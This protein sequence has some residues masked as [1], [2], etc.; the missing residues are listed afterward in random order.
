MFEE[1][2]SVQMAQT[3]ASMVQWVMSASDDRPRSQS[4][5][6]VEDIDLSLDRIASGCRFSSIELREKVKNDDRAQLCAKDE[7]SSIFRHIHSS[8]AKWLIRLVLKTLSPIE[9]P[10]AATLRRFHFLLPDLLQFQN[11]L[12]ACV[13]LLEIDMIRQMPSQPSREVQ[14]RMRE[15]ASHRLK[16]EV[17]VM[18]SPSCREKGRGIQHCCC[19]IAGGRTMSIERKYDGEYCQVHVNLK[20]DANCNQRE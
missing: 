12:E 20:K 9:I 11:S 18:I 1:V 6:T 16:P 10:E 5:M 7:L 19:Q 8:E 13:R 17:G 4:K 2:R 14:K 15:S 3:F